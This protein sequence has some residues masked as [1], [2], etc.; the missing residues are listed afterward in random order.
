M[1]STYELLRCM[2]FSEMIMMNRRSYLSV[3]HLFGVSNKATLIEA[4]HSAK[5]FRGLFRFNGKV[6]IL[7]DRFGLIKRLKKLW[8]YLLLFSQKY[9][10]KFFTKICLELPGSVYK[11]LHFCVL[12]LLFLNN[13]HYVSYCHF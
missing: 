1:L 10:K 2:G 12:F 5:T 6:P 4:F 7:W 9:H 13:G 3:L 8:A 11:F